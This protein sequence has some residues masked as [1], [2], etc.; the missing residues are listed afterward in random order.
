MNKE[1]TCA[2]V[3]DLLPN[4][5]EE[6]TSQRTTEFVDQHLRECEACRKV[7]RAMEGP[8]TAAEQA[9]DELVEGIKR[10]RTRAKKR[11]W[12]F[13]LCI[14]I[15]LC[16]GF[17]PL[18]R[19][20]NRTVSAVRWQPDMEEYE[21]ITVDIKGIYLDFFFHTDIF[22]GDIAIEGVPQSQK[23]GRMSRIYMDKDSYPLFWEDDDAML[24]AGGFIVSMPGMSK[25]MIGLN[26]ED[27]SW[28]GNSGV[29][30]TVPATTRE[31]A[32]SIANDICKNN[33]GRWLS[34]INWE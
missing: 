16:I 11:A 2:V 19:T 21:Q 25:F 32:V 22:E 29:N 15:V 14:A 6:M 4:Y 24:R 18:P 7:K 27:G 12:L 3:C 30:I 20:I 1:Q 34:D 8:V 26:D 13:I 9:R 5:L 17:L 28:D 31:E 10:A 33:G 23:T